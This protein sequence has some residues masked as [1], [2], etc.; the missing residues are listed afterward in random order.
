MTA[1]KPRRG[2]V[3]QQV[4]AAKAEHLA[5][6]QMR[7]LRLAGHDTGPPLYDETVRALAPPAWETFPGE[8]APKWRRD[9]VAVFAALVLLALV[10]V[11]FFV[12]TA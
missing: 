10:A 3:E 1:P 9:E 7:I 2:Y 11:V 12:V 6:A 5:A 4:A 8:P